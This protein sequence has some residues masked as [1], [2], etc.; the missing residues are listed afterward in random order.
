MPASHNILDDFLTA[1]GIDHTHTFAC[2]RYS[3]MDFHTFYGLK[4]ELEE[5]DVDT[6]GYRFDADTAVE[7]VPVPSVVYLPECGAVVLTSAS[8]DE[9]SLY[10]AGEASAMVTSEF[11]KS[12]NREALVVTS[13]RHAR[14]PELEQ[15][16]M[17]V[18]MATMARI[19][20]P[21]LTM[22]IIAYFFVVNGLWR[23]WSTEAITLLDCVGLFLTW[24]LV[25]KTLGF[26]NAT[27]DRVC[28]VLQEGGCD[29]VLATSA[30][31]LFGVFA[32]SEVGL[33][34][35]SVS[36]ACLLF[37]PEYT[38]YLA[39]I[40]L[41]CLPY[42]FWRI[43]YQRYRAKAWCTLC[44]GTMLTLWLL[45][46]CYLGGGFF[47]SVFPLRLPFFILGAT[48]ILILLALTRLTPYIHPITSQ[49]K[50]DARP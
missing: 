50:S 38:P 3:A 31:K 27:A 25:Q 6:A 33:S 39:A 24:H 8:Q 9:V 1:L 48:Y 4:K 15:H 32:W 5:F 19:G 34:Y 37:W 16:R 26:T 41:L 10:H 28:R 14:E 45:F 42:S 30:S 17:T 35:F 49:N 12:W 18:V 43:W 40:N 7:A 21:V 46:G 11:L 44:C 2:E 36:L 13:D 29:D 22:A 20:L 47:S 23:H